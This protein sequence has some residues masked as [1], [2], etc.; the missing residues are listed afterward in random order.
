MKNKGNKFAWIAWLV[1]L[2]VLIVLPFTNIQMYYIH[3]ISLS[4]IWVVMTQGLN[5]I[6]GLTGYVSIGQASFFGI[7]A[8]T[9][10]LLSI[11]FGMNFWLAAIIGILASALAGLIIGY[12]SLRTKGHYFSIITLAFCFVI[13]SLMGT[14]KDL[15]GGTSGLPNI[16]QPEFFAFLGLSKR[17]GYYL[18][19]LIFAV[20]ATLFA[21]KLKNSKYGRAF[22][23]IRENEEL[24]QAVGISL[25][26]FKL[27]SFVISATMGGI[28]GV[29][30]AHF[31]QFINPT[32]FSTDYSMNAILAIIMGGSGT[33]VGPVVGAFLL[34]FL[35]ELLRM[36]DAFRNIIY[37]ILLIIITIFMPKGISYAI[38]RLFEIIVGAF[39]KKNEASK[40]S[41]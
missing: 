10:A 18:F 26:K 32:S 27:L 24:A 35:P 16:P 12:P 23:I 11:N 8:Y 13:F 5:I 1:V 7:G 33:I 38:K 17:H 37:A 31:A 30:Y 15:T 2:A 28:A 4:L 29:L 19:V 14:L 40:D 36:A 21:Y 34:Q 9:S 3:L 25:V 39:K 22:L 6:Q 20:L 41:K